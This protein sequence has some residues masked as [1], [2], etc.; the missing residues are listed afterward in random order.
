[1]EKEMNEFNQKLQKNK[2]LTRALFMVFFIIVYSISKF[3]VIGFA[4]FQLITLLMTEKLNTQ[5]LGFTQGLSLY[6]FQITQF[7]TFNS[8]TKPFPFSAWPTDK[9]ALNNVQEAGNN[10]LD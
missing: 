4:I 2:L 3:L 5:I 7:V 8:E 9:D 10:K 6:I 1:M